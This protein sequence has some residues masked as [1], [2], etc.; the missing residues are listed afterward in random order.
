MA[1]ISKPFTFS[2]GAVIIA[3]EHNSNFDTIYNDYNTNITN[4]NISASAAIA[5]SKLNLQTIAQTMS[6]SSTAVNFAKGSDIASAT[7]TDIGAMAGNYAD[8]TGTTTIT[9]L[10]TV[11]A[12]TVRYV[13]FT[14]AL[15]LTYNATSLM[16]PTAASITTVAGDT[17]AFVSLGSGNWKC[18]WYQRYDGTALVSATA[19]SALSG[20][21]IQTVN[22][23]VVTSS[24]GTT[25]IPA[26]DTIPQNT[27][28]TEFMTLA[29]TPNNASNKLKILVVFNGASS[30]GV[31]VAGALFQDSTANALSACFATGS[32]SAGNATFQLVLEHYMSAGTTSS[33][34]FKFRVGGLAATTITMN[35]VNGS[36]YFGGILPSSI[37]IQEIKA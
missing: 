18:L 7:T 4:T 10:G 26:D 25:V 21:V 1:T 28:G 12:G 17:A 34:T 16:L 37:T 9:G 14:G 6:M 3:S 15:T 27:E 30:G 20:S 2:A 23:L 35:G 31:S 36:R 22:T 33:T 8:I 5:A 19:A 32:I 24:T 13:R 29:I 11:Q